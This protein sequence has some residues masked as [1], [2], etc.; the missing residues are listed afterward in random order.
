M[1]CR[2]PFCE[3]NQ[4]DRPSFE[5]MDPA[6]CPFAR[7]AFGIEHPPGSR[8]PPLPL[9]RAFA[10]RPIHL[11]G[12]AVVVLYLRRALPGW[13]FPL[14]ALAPDLPVRVT[15][16]PEGFILRWQVVIGVHAPEPDRLTP[17][18][19][20]R[21]KAAASPDTRA[22]LESVREMRRTGDTGKGLAALRY[23]LTRTLLPRRDRT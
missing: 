13:I 10:W 17:E 6:S 11:P 7:A 23:Y 20:A 8:L 12:G 2:C 16:S 14:V 5:I 15:S 3:P 18:E 19:R 21:A 1:R 22:F 4:A 9:A